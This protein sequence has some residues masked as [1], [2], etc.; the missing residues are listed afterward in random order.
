M[1]G[2]KKNTK[3]N[4]EKT[5]NNNT[6]NPLKKKD[7][8]KSSNY[9]KNKKI[10]KNIN[11][12]VGGNGNI[13]NFPKKGQKPPVLS[14]KSNERKNNNEREKGKKPLAAPKKKRSLFM[15]HI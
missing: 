15:I 11:A 14:Q 7:N 2:E 10:N 8:V 5:K 1:I 12:H 13:S 4:L 3:A 6:F 9:D